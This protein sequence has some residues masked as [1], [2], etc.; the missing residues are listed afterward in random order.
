MSNE[1]K[2]MKEMKE[3]KEGLGIG[4]KLKSGVKKIW[5]KT[6]PIRDFVGV[7]VREAAIGAAVGA[8]MVGGMFFM[9]G[10]LSG[11]EGTEDEPGSS[12]ETVNKEDESGE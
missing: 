3:Q 6:E 12:E 1:V 10:K 7:T 9:A 2:E 5:Q 11:G 8:A 4:K